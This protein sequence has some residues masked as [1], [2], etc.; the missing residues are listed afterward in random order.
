M[1]SSFKHAFHPFC[2]VSARKQDAVPAT[3]AL[4]A[5]V[6]PEADD[7]PIAAAAG[8]RLPQSKHIA[9]AEIGQHTVIILIPYVSMRNDLI[10][11]AFTIWK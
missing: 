2:Q 4:D 10:P 9:E 8:V 7:G 11:G 6:R 5:N 1:G 3:P